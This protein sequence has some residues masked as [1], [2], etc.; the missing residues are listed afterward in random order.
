MCHPLWLV[1]RSTHSHTTH[2]HTRKWKLENSIREICRRRRLNHIRLTYVA[3]R[4]QQNMI[5]RR[6]D[7]RVIYNRF[8]ESNPNRPFTNIRPMLNADIDP[9]EC[10]RT[11]SMVIIKE[12][13]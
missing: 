7:P 5:Y 6:L 2:T 8:I 4:G 1:A 12:K 9:M 3:D 10:T 13:S 11:A